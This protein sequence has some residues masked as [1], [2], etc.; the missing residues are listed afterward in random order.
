MIVRKP[1]VDEID[2]M[3]VQHGFT[4]EGTGFHINYSIKYRIGRENE[5]ED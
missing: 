5:E 4:D 3:L 2:H 1:K